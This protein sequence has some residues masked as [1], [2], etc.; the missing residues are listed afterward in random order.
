[1][2]LA[3][4]WR[5]CAA[6][7]YRSALET[8]VIGEL[9]QARAIRWWIVRRTPSMSDVAAGTTVCGDRVAHSDQ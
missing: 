3:T 7:R 8:L 4:S 5:I 2:G 6:W 1:M 9:L